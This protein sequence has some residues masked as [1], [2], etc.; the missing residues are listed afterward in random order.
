MPILQEQ[1]TK[2]QVHCSAFVLLAHENYATPW[3]LVVVSLSVWVQRF[4]LCFIYSCFKNLFWSHSIPS[5]P[6]TPARWSPSASCL[7]LFFL[8]T[9]AVLVKKAYTLIHASYMLV[10]VGQPTRAC[11]MANLLWSRI[12]ENWLPPTPRTHQLSITSQLGPGAHELLSSPCWKVGSLDPMQTSIA[13]VS[14]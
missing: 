9:F 12:E 13:A 14:S 6:P 2:K 4:P 10:G 11:I 3:C 5:L 7:F 8:I 1:A